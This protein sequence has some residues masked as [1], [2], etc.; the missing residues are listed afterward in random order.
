MSVAL[1]RVGGPCYHSDL[2]G[3]TFWI[4]EKNEDFLLYGTI[5]YNTGRFST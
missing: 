4:G 3:G 2:P 1:V 5:L